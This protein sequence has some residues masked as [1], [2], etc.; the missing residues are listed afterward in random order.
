MEFEKF[1]Q[2]VTE[3]AKA[4]GLAEYEL[5]YATSESMRVNTFAHEINEVSSSLEGGVCFRCLVN[6]KMGYASAEELSAETAARIVRRAQDNAAAL[7][8][9]E[10]EFLAGGGG[11][12]R[13]LPPQV[14]GMP[15]TET[16]IRKALDAQAA[17]YDEDPAV[18]DGTNAEMIGMRDTVA[19]CNSR[20][21]DVS[22]ERCMTALVAAPVVSD[23]Q[24]MSN[25]FEILTGDAASMDYSATVKKAVQAAKGKLGA[26]VAPTGAYPVVLGPKAVASLLTAYSGIFSSENAAKGLSRLQGREGEKIAA[27]VVTLTDDPF[28]KDS[29]MPADF[30]AEGTPTRTKAIIENGVLKTLLYNLKTAAA[31]GKETTGNASKAGYDAPVQIRPFTLALAPGALTEAEL[32]EKAGDGVF[33][34]DFSGLHAGANPISGDFSL[35]SSGYMLEGGKKTTAVKSFTVAGNFYTLLNQITALSDT[36]EYV[37]MGGVASPCVLVEGLTVAGK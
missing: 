20:G 10:P 12:Y 4:L 1:K 25:A 37:F 33:V 19:I 15:E 16:L 13:P 29:P 17:M 9:E 14:G 6:G 8:S 27:D 35:Q 26:D 32:L 21:L 34:D 18:I 7:E 23:G 3:E 36:A 24:E 2:L 30:D 5:Y 28:Y 11:T 31:A 22:R